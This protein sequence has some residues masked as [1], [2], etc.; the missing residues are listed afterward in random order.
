M[1]DSSVG[2]FSRTIYVSVT[3]NRLTVADVIA[4]ADRL[5]EMHVP[6]AEQVSDDHAHESG[7]LIGL[8]VRYSE[9]LPED[10]A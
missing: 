8:R 2:D 1:I 9:R 4:Y 6:L 5:R 3:S 10:P 7:H